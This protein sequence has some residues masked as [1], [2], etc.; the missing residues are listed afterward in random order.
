MGLYSRSSQQFLVN[1][2]IVAHA[3]DAARD[4]CLDVTHR[5]HRPAEMSSMVN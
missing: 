1:V 2:Y 5:M 4:Q 3:L